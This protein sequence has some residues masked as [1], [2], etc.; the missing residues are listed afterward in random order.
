MDLQLQRVVSNK[1]LFLPIVLSLNLF[2]NHDDLLLSYRDIMRAE[3]QTKRCKNEGD[4]SPQNRF[5]PQ[6]G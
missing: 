6:D 1:L 2:L 3:K 4:I 5:K